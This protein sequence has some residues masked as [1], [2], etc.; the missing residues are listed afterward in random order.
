MINTKKII[1]FLKVREENVIIL[2]SYKALS[3]ICTKPLFAFT[4]VGNNPDQ[5]MN[6]DD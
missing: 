5:L 3:L 4:T 2:T 6:A 1:F